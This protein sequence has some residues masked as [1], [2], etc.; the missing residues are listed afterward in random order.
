MGPTCTIRFRLEAERIS[1]L[2]GRST[3]YRCLVRHGLIEARGPPAQRPDYKRWE[4]G[5]AMECGRWTLSVV[6]VVDGWRAS[7]VS[8]VDDLAGL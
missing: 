6:C 2:P 1:P 5:R 8:G 7:I 4:R 3:V